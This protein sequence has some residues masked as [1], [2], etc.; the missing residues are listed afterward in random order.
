[1]P[2]INLFEKNNGLTA[3][4]NIYHISE[5]IM[6]RIVKRC[7]V[8]EGIDYIVPD[9]C[10]SF[11]LEE[12]G[13]HPDS[14]D[15][16]NVRIHCRHITTAF[17]SGESIKSRGLVSLNKLLEGESYLRSFL[18]ENA[19]VVSPS[20][21]FIEIKGKK[22]KI[23]VTSKNC[24]Y[25]TWE[26]FCMLSSSLY[27]DDGEVEAFVEGEQ[28]K[29]LNYSTVRNHPEILNSID[30]T[31][32]KLTGA[33]LD[34]GRKWMIRKPTTFIADFDVAIKDLSY[35]NKKRSRTCFPD[36]LNALMPFCEYNNPQNKMMWENDWIIRSCI[37][38]NCPG[39]YMC[40]CAVGIKS[41]AEIPGK[42]IM[43]REMPKRE[44]EGRNIT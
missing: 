6:A 28:S 37:E 36:T 38:N 12:T 22:Y 9:D 35:N 19:V 11:F 5:P 25:N 32:K 7:I 14:F 3:L 26:N 8:R 21:Q 18:A 1:M 44:I 17:D 10:V 4:Q 23:P 43:L 33:D 2:I 34:L 16:S 41:T 20:K 31:V 27:H 15:V 13:V 24:D 42:S 40:E 39:V 29:I 30:Y